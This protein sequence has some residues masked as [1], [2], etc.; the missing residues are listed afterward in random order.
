MT[1]GWGDLATIAIANTAAFAAI[2]LSHTSG[3]PK[4]SAP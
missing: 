1:P 2:R 4:A 3:H